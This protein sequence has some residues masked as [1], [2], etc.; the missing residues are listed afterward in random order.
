MRT[1]LRTT[2]RSSPIRRLPPTTQPR[3]RCARSSRPGRQLNRLA[4][5]G[6]CQ[7]PAVWGNAVIVKFN[8][9]KIGLPKRATVTLQLVNPIGLAD[10]A[11]HGESGLHGWG[12]AIPPDPNLLY[13]RGFDPLARRFIYDVN[14]RFGSTRPSESTTHLLPYVALS[15]NYDIGVSRERQVLTQQLDRGRRGPGDRLNIETLRNL[16]TSAIP[17]PMRMMMEQETALGLT[18]VQADSLANL[19]RKFAVFAD[20]VWTPVANYLVSLPDTYSHTEA[21]GR[22]VSARERTVDFLLSIAPHASGLLTPSQRRKLPIQISNY[23]D[24][25]VLEF[26]RSSTLGDASPVGGR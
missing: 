18:R 22:Y 3:R 21:Y 9:L 26:L 17:N 19:S 20:S 2:A 12:Q 8:P 1:V 7:A 15:L 4:E 25:R 14:Q 24:R 16:G 11:L 6:S 5:R 13:V 23:L 10:L